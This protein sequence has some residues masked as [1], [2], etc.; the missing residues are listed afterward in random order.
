M[1]KYVLIGLFTLVPF[2]I[3]AQVDA[4]YLRGAVP[5]VD[6]KVLFSKT[7]VPNKPMETRTTWYTTK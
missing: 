4:K 6:G 7:I 3:Q 5:E 2:I 1:K